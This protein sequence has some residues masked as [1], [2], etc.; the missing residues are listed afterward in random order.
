[1]RMV[2]GNLA[3]DILD[4]GWG[5]L[6]QR[7][8]QKAESAGRM[9]VLAD[10]RDTSKT[11][12]HCGHS[13]ETLSLADRWINC[14]CGLTLDRGHNATINILKR[15]GQLRWG[16]SSPGGGSPKEAAEF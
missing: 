2:H 11:C 5:Y 3:K 13:F 10:P 9:I 8:T 12:S 6:V 7:L 16:I 1:M 14:A 15:G 4:A